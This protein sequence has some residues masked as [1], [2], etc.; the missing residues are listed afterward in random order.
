MEDML[1]T[2]EPSTEEGDPL[3][4]IISR[5]APD[6]QHNTTL[7]TQ[8]GRPGADGGDSSTLPH[9]DHAEQPEPGGAA[10]RGFAGH[11]D[12]RGIT[13]LT[14]LDENH[15]LETVQNQ[16]AQMLG[17]TAALVP[18]ATDL[19]IAR[20]LCA[21]PAT[22]G[23]ATLLMPQGSEDSQRRLALE[24]SSIL[25]RTPSSDAIHR[26][27]AAICLQQQKTA[28]EMERELEQLHDSAMAF[29]GPT[30]PMPPA[31]PHPAGQTGPFFETRLPQMQSALGSGYS[32]GAQSLSH[33]F[34]NQNPAAGHFAAPASP[35]PGPFGAM[36][37]RPS[38]G[39]P[40]Q[41]SIPDILLQSQ[42]ALSNRFSAG[43]QSFSPNTQ[44]VAAAPTPCGCAYLNNQSSTSS[45]ASNTFQGNRADTSDRA[46]LPCFEQL[47]S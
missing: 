45:R 18:Y 1:Q 42:S 32:A 20:L 9:A 47:D 8:E 29:T 2:L 46:C 17:E 14:P 27:I 10:Q 40:H 12:A 28:F 5:G 16:R 44:F 15:L 26:R 3:A 11:A 35:A 37:F 13:P 33:P 19:G 25:N 30:P 31:T 6:H 34:S 21:D 7:A 23:G 36:P 4:S 22:V 24:L 38:G 41:P 43:A 39:A